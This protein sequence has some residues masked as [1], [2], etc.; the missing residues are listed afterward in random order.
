MESRRRSLTLLAPLR[1]S[2]R[3]KAVIQNAVTHLLATYPKSSLID[4]YKSFF[5][6][7][8]GPGHLLEDPSRARRYFEEEL[9]T[10]K[11]NHR[12]CIEACGVGNNY[13]RVPMDLILDGV[14]SKEHYW[15]L[16]VTSAQAAKAVTLPAWINTWQE[17]ERYIPK[18]LRNYR[19]DTQIITELFTKGEFVLGHSDEYRTHYDPHYRLFTNANARLLSLGLR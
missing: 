3:A 6:D 10:M 15:E 2:L 16:F 5:Q 9:E 19:E 13:V 1:L 4:L 7:E 14:V 12:A 8:Y 18:T 11:S 17:I